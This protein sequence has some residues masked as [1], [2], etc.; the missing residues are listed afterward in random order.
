MFGISGVEFSVILLVA[1]IVVGPK[2]L[3]ELLKS[4]GR[5]YR[6]FNRFVLKYRRVLDDALYDADEQAEK[7]R[8]A[9]NDG[10]RPHD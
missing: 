8:D 4:A 6:A 2:Q 9:L 5:L 7:I 1:L 3:P 10:K